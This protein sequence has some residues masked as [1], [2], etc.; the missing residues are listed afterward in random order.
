MT[1]LGVGIVG[2]GFGQIIHIPGFQ[3]CQGTTIVGVYHYDQVR[4]T[5][6]A[7]KFQI[8][9]ACNRLVDL[10]ALPDIQ[11][12]AIA[13]PPFL[14]Y[15]AAHLA[16][17]AGKHLLLEKP[18]TMNVHEAIALEQ[19]AAAKHLV[20]GVDFEFRLVPQWIYFR[21]LLASQKI[22]KIRSINI[23]WQVP[24]RANPQ[25][26]WNWYSQKDQGGGALGAI[27]SHAFDYLEWLFGEVRSLVADLKTTVPQRPDGNG[28]WRTVDAD[29]TCHILLELADGTPVNMSLSTV[30]YGGAGHWLTVHGDSGTLI[31]GSD[32][33]NDYIHGF[34]IYY[35]EPSQARQVL[36]MPSDHEF[37]Q[38]Y[39]DGRLAPFIALVDRLV[40]AINHHTTMVP[41]MAAG[42]RS[43]HLI[44]LAHQS[45]HERR[46][47]A[48]A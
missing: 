25:R 14:H 13:T 6:I 3:I 32:N 44:D 43:Q 20:I 5:T 40:T 21:E 10:Y 37:P 45:H 12:I 26:L 7:N 4:A 41:G 19:L 29:D 34:E 1:K 2:T 27:G 24:S 15:E 48:C 46:W 11:I 38:T 28:Q 30:A 36:A 8:P 47:I 18:V 33:L 31:L 22:G 42:V 9:H 39:A 23:Q 35:V 17:E 16:L